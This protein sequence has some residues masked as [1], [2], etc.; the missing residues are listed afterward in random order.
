M[1]GEMDG[2]AV[3]MVQRGDGQRL[4]VARSTVRNDIVLFK[5]LSGE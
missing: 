1:S 3:R 5:E 4:A 2:D